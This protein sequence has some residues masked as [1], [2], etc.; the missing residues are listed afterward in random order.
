MDSYKSRGFPYKSDMFTTG[1]DHF[2]YGHATR[3]VGMGFRMTSS[4]YLTQANKRSNVTIMT[5][6]LVD[7]LK[8]ETKDGKIAATGV[9]AISEDGSKITLN[10][11][12]EVILSAGSYCTPAILLRSGIG[13]KEE[14]SKHGI[15][16]TVEL[17]GV[18]K[19]LQDHLVSSLRAVKSLHH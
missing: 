4:Q 9:H 5:N 15:E 18:G 7:K 17:P 1:K 14:V 16:Q 6:T 8:L 12:S 2:G 3:T 13:G 11:K 10:A 19:N